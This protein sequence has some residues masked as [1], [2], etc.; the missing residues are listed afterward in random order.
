MA[1]KVYS[2]VPSQL[3]QIG[4]VFSLFPFPTQF[5]FKVIGNHSRISFIGH[6]SSSPVMSFDEPTHVYIEVTDLKHD[7]RCVCSRCD[8][9]LP[10]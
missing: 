10:F 7:K 2:T 9:L 5:R 4:D 3:L 8:A 6:D 1:R